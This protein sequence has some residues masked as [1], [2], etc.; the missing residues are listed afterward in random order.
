M[1]DARPF[2]P[3]GEGSPQGRH[4][5]ARRAM[6]WLLAGLVT[7]QFA[8][9]LTLHNLQSLAYGQALLA[10]HH[11]LGVAVLAIVLIHAV[12][13]FGR[14]RR[15]PDNRFPGWQRR[16]ARGAH[17]AML[18]VLGFQSAL[19]IVTAWSRGD[20]ILLLGFVKLPVLLELSVEQGI[21]AQSWHR[22]LAFGFLALLAAHVGAVLFNHLCRKVP[23]M[24]RM[25]PR[26]PH[27][28]MTN[29]VPV[30][31]QLACGCGTIVM[32]VACAGLYSAS[33]YTEFNTLR[34]QFDEIEVTSVDNMR[35]LQLRSHDLSRTHLSQEEM[36]QARATL[37]ADMRSIASQA[38]PQTGAALVENAARLTE[39]GDESSLERAAVAFDGVVDSA[40]M[41]LFEKRLEIAQTAAEGHD[42]IILALLP[43]IMFG[44]ALAIVMSR[45]ILRALAH[46]RRSVREIGEGCEEAGLAVVGREIGRASCRERVLFE[47]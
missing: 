17:A 25:L 28:Q 18:A 13:V 1:S 24:G 20:E 36:R 9:I 12:L 21:A 26:A 41:R 10:L 14:S 40:S 7:I 44:A 46:V 37:A 6:H 34:A 3:Q 8:L 15:S 33:R 4:S 32:L 2:L 16:A 22:W 23:V 5:R 11:Q 31:V 47:V 29:R 45:S 38:D 19:G 35:A 30:F 39:D 27:R 43:A 42:L